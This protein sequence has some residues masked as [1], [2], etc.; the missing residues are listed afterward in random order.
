MLLG[1]QGI[2]LSRHRR[3]AFELPGGSVEAGESRLA[4]GCCGV[5]WRVAEHLPRLLEHGA[6]EHAADGSQSETRPG[7]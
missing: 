2:L 6:G 1:G 3:G 5:G 4:L 7:W